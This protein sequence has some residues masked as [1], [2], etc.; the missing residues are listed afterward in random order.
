[1]R[2]ARAASEPSIDER[3][4]RAVAWLEQ[5]GTRKVRD[6]M[7]RFGIPQD[8]AFGVS[9]AGIQR[10]AGRLG[11][12]HRLAAAL[13]GS[14]WY[15]A[16]MAAAYVDDPAEVTSAQMDR[17]A[18]EFGNWAI[19]DTVCF[20]L[21]DRTPYAWAKVKLW[22][23]KRDEFVKR[24]A[25]AL[26]WGLTVHDKGTA[27][28]PFIDGLALIENAASDER[29]YVKKAVSM[30]LRATGKRNSALNARAIATGRRLANAPG[31]TARWIGKDAVRELTSPG[32]ARRLAKQT[33]GNR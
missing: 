16:R 10:L 14:G 8:R 13:W 11:K 22:S 1:M 21:F 24:G 26:L 32:V 7:V 4:A 19:C 18:G 9:M 6:S 17:W 15:E 27:N 30:A 12:S 33:K 28:Q 23:G 3:V 5:R 20:A 29:H 31:D 25:F 2:A